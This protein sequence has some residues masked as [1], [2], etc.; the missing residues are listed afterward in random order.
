MTS[1]C[2]VSTGIA[3]L[4]PLLCGGLPA[5]RLYLIQGRPGTGKTTLA[6]Q[7]LLEGAQRGERAVYV[8][9][10]E[11]ASELRG[12]AASHGWSLADVELCQLHTAAAE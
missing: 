3:G 8:T 2:V 6:L 5:D 12:I 4:D 7:F 9:L 11:T 10:S 1:E